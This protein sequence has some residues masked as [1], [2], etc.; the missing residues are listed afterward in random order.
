MGPFAIQA[1]GMLELV[2]DRLHNL[3]DASEPAPQRLG[4]RRLTI[5]LG[6]ADDLGP[7]GRPPRPMI[8]LALKALVDDV[9]TLCGR[10]DTGQ[11]RMR[12]AAQGK[13]R[14]R[15]RLILGAGR[16]NAQA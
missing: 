3:A 5:P 6:R 15:Q 11:A 14:L 10:P 4:P 9:R 1:A 12:L 16:P 13:K 7:V 8:A 2:M